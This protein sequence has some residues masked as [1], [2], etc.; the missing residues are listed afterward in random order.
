MRWYKSEQKIAAFCLSY[1]S[2]HSKSLSATSQEKKWIGR[3]QTTTE[4]HAFEHAFAYTSL[5]CA[6]L[7][8]WAAAGSHQYGC[9]FQVRVWCKWYTD[10][11]VCAWIYD[12]CFFGNLFLRAFGRIWRMRD[13]TSERMRKRWQSQ[14][15]HT[16]RRSA[17]RKQGPEQCVC[18]LCAAITRWVAQ[19]KMAVVSFTRFGDAINV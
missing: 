11:I 19:K 13:G 12:R 16:R 6:I 18:K 10:D 14:K 3:R 2:M 5:C 9:K 17:C 1:C 8:R 15:L 4:K 7:S